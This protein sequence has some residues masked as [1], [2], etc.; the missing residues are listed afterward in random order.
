MLNIK[1]LL[2][3]G[4]DIF[5]NL[6][7]GSKQLVG[8]DVGSSS[9]KLAEMQETPKGYILNRFFQM[10]L[11]KGLPTRKYSELKVAKALQKKYDDVFLADWMFQ[12]TFLL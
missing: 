3:G 10:P 4:V 1:N 12:I 8:L 2:S 5:K 6:L 11:E 7:P 9:I